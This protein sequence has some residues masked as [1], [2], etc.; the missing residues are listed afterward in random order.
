MQKEPAGID[1]GYSMSGRLNR[2]SNQP[3]TKLRPGG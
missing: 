2:L 1:D 3:H